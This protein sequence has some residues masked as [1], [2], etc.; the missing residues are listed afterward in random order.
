MRIT[1]LLA[2]ASLCI[3]QAAGA[4]LPDPVAS[5]DGGRVEGTV[6]PSGVKAFFGIPFAAPPVGDLRWRD[7]QSVTPWRA[8]YHADRLAPQC[9]QQQRGLRA[10]Q[11]SGPEVTSEDCLYLNVW[12]KPGVRKA[13]VIVFILRRR[14]LH[15]VGKHGAVRRRKRG[16]GGRSLRQL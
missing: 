12:A 9:M 8:T 3:A 15:R 5:I 2:V 14:L 1:R 6:L 4:A 7:P 11:Y 16:Q 13:P 10:N